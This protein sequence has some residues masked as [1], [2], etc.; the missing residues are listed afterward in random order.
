MAKFSQGFMDVLSRTGTPQA[1]MQQ[2]QQEAPAYGSLQRNLGAAFNMDQR[3]RPEMTSAEIDKIDPKAKDALRQ[4]L[5]VSAKYEQDPQRKLLMLA[6]VAE[7]DK[8]KQLEDEAKSKD[9]VSRQL[10]GGRA[11]QLYTALS[12]LN[13]ELAQMVASGDPEAFKAGVEWLTENNKK[14]EAIKE[15]EYAKANGWTGDFAAWQKI[16]MSQPARKLENSTYYDDKSGREMKRFFYADAPNVTIREDEVPPDSAKTSATIDKALGRLTSEA[17]LL[18]TRAD[19]AQRLA[20][21]ML[22]LNPKSGIGKKGTEFFKELW[23]SQDQQTLL[24]KQAETLRAG[25]A[26]RNLPPGVASDAD[27]ALVL[28]GE[29]PADASPETWALYA[30]G[31][32]RL[33]RMEQNLVQDHALWLSN[34]GTERGYETYKYVN[35]MR[36]ADAAVPAEAKLDLKNNPETLPQ[37]ITTFGYDP[38]KLVSAEAELDS[39]KKRFR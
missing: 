35:R 18:Q 15:Y 27:I 11:Q 14:S 37:Y 30:Q 28:A 22:R 7:L 2:G 19:S 8:S 10:Q 16:N 38:T 12:P 20:D 21:D 4:S 23:G 6:K 26:I 39:I 34:Y 5:L 31:I 36:E 33:T 24:Y 13:P 1:A 9:L 17:S 25:N 29:L 32:A 3:S